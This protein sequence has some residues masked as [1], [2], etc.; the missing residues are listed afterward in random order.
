MIPIFP[1]S[2]PPCPASITTTGDSS[3]GVC[4]SSLSTLTAFTVS[5]YT[6]VSLPTTAMAISS[7]H[8]ITACNAFCCSIP[9]SII[10]YLNDFICFLLWKYLPKIK[11]SFCFPLLHPV[12]DSAYNKRMK[13]NKNILST[14]LFIFAGICILA[15]VILFVK[16]HMADRRMEESLDE[17]RPTAVTEDSTNASAEATE[18]VTS[19]S[20]EAVAEETTVPTEEFDRVPNPYADSFAANGDMAA[21]LQIPDTN[22]DYP[23]MW[24]PKDETY[25][26]YRAFDG[27]KNKNGCLLL[28]D[29]SCVDPLTTNLIIHGHNMKSGAMFGNLTDYENQDFYEKHKNIIL[30]TE[31]CQRNYEVIAVF[32]SQV[33]RKTD[34]VFKFYKFFQADTQEEFDDFYNN[35]K[36]LSQYDTGVTAE[37][38]DHFLTLSTCVYHVE[39]GRFVVVAKEVEPGD[40]YLPVQE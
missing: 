14:I 1:G 3:P 20:T 2:S 26:L 37:F 12:T 10:L 38:G 40:H 39:Q 33:Y 31:E 30:Y 25:Y 4:R 19:V 5:T 23:V 13:S 9:V 32:R 36:Q 17:L 11:K 8:I 15:A 35:I 29:E 27:S 18:A 34:Q 24:T 7:R 28:D 21:W 6:A 22:I 16:G